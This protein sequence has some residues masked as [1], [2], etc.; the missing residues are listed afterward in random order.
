MKFEINKINEKDIFNNNMNCKT[1][2]YYF[3]NFPHFQ[4]PTVEA[5]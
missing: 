1:P 4:D 3:D 5:T 2:R